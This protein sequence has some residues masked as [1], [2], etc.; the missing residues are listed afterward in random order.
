MN[1]ICLYHKNEVSDHNYTNTSNDKAPPLE[2]TCKSRCPKMA[3]FNANASQNS[4][5]AMQN[6][7]F[8][9]AVSFS[10]YFL[11]FKTF[12]PATNCFG[13]CVGLKV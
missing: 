13:D 3:R 2:L 8:H 1:K 12:Q 11:L 6:A 9:G 10:F 5:R 4:V 7:Y